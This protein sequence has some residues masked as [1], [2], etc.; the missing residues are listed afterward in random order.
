MFL[1]LFMVWRST[2][3]VVDCH[4]DSNIDTWII[5]SELLFNVQL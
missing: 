3:E 2:C 5:T 1:A 4:Y